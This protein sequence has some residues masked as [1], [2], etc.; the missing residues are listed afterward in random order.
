MDNFEISYRSK[1][2]EEVPMLATASTIINNRKET[3]G[4]A[5]ISRDM[6]EIRKLQMMIMQTEKMSA[7]G[8]LAAGVAHEINNPLAAI[9]GFAQGMRSRLLADDSFAMPVRHIER[10]AL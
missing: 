5:V 2:T 1:H 3:I 10:E 8:Q 9:L 7:V 4:I 6:R